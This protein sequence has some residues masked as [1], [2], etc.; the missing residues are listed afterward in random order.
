[1]A[2]LNLPDQVESLAQR[3]IVFAADLKPPTKKEELKSPSFTHY[4][5]KITMKILY[6]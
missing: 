3:F 4:N 1:M 2:R 5:E 6:N